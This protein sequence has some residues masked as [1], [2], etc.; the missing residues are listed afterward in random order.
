MTTVINLFGGSG[1][2]KS[3]TAAHVYVEMKFAGKHVELVREYVKTWAWRG[4][5]IGPFD[6]V[7]LLGKQAR[8]ESQLYGKV[9]YIV[10]DSPL[11]L[12]PIYEK[13]YTGKDIIGQ[14]AINFLKDAEDKGVKHLNFLLTRNKEFDPRGRYETLEQA[15]QVDEAARQFLTDNNIPFVEISTSD[16][17]RAAEILKHMV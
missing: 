4:E 1:I 9:D 11:L 10:T 16:R 5:K 8:Y 3:T 15:S 14:A 17:E 7:Y 2:G 6:Q 13:Y 12:C